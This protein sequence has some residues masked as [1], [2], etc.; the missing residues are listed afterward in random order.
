M[1]E[2]DEQFT[3]KTTG[4]LRAIAIDEAASVVDR[5]R[6]IIELGRRAAKEP[7]LAADLLEW[8][9][10][11]NF[12]GSR[13]VGQVTLAWIAALAVGYSQSD[14]QTRGRL[15]ETLNRWESSERELLLSWA[16]RE[17]WLQDMTP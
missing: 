7:E 17:T 4:Q 15:R 5:G 3:L 13:W 16:S 6:A 14:S 2:P 8:A 9:D 1:F 10:T 12:Q 11:P